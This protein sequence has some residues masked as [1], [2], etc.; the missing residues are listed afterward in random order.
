MLGHD[1][2]Y[3]L[4]C[5]VFVTNN[6]RSPSITYQWI[7]NNDTP[8]VQVGETEPDTLSFISFR[9]S[10][11]GLYTCY[12]TISSSSLGSDISVTA[13]HEVKIQSEL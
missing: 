8:A 4:T 13:S 3:T 1:S 5:R 7:K 10:D 11:A 9:L 12:A 2:S 6:F